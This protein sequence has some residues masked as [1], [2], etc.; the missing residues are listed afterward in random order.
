M[1]SLV[2]Q[3]QRAFNL[4]YS[5]FFLDIFI[6][7]KYVTDRQFKSI[8]KMSNH[9]RGHKNAQST[10]IRLPHNIFFQYS[11]LLVRLEVQNRLKFDS[12]G[13]S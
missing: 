10:L 8:Y 7:Y 2:A 5:Y 13:S 9:N 3:V 12:L 11:T 4:I 6:R 1:L